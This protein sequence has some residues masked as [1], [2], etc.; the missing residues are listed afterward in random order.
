[1]T[2]TKML[3]AVLLLTVSVA[4]L[5]GP[6]SGASA[7][8]ASIKA[9]L[10][11]AGPQITSAEK[12][13]ASAIVAYKTSHEPAAVESALAKSI[14]VLKSTRTKVASQSAGSAAVKLAKSK[15]VKGL[16]AVAAA[17]VR[18]NS[19]FAQHGSDPQAANTEAEAALKKV[20]TGRK[21][22]KEAVKLLS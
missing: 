6:V 19:A 3:R 11:S 21:Q 9:V 17:Y 2:R 18:L 4:V 13:V 15:I 7:S 16:S 8:K 22:L 14:A 1:M 10:K 5:A 20:A 12:G